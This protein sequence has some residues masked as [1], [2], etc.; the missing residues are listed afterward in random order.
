MSTSPPSATLSAIDLARAAAR[1]S[2]YGSHAAPTAE[3]PD[4]RRGPAA[5]SRYV[6]FSDANALTAVDPLRDA[7]DALQPAVKLSDLKKRSALAQLA[8]DMDTPP[9]TGQPQG[10]YAK[11]TVLPVT[12]AATADDTVIAS[13]FTLGGMIRNARE[14][15]GLS[16][17][18]LA[19]KANVG[20]RFVSEVENGKAT[21][22][23]EKVLKVAAAAGVRLT[24]RSAP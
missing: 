24:A 1:S 15:R 18:K 11:Q 21:L 22:E 9:R 5:R 19:E 8:R 4:R 23:F 20:R 14:K 12:D 3:T 7:G 13:T 10:S 16:Q 2:Q 17:Q 6:L